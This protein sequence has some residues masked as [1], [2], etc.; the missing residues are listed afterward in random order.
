MPNAVEARLLKQDLPARD[1]KRVQDAVNTYYNLHVKFNKDKLSQE[2]KWRLF[3]RILKNALDRNLA[4]HWH[5]A[6]GNGVGY[7]CKV[8]QGAMGIWKFPDGCVVVIWK[9]PGL[10]P[11][12]ESVKEEG[13]K[14]EKAVRAKPAKLLFGDAKAEVEAVCQE[15]SSVDTK[16]AQ[17]LAAAI[18]KRLTKDFGPIWH[19]LAG[20][21]FVVEMGQDCRNEFGIQVGDTRIVGFQHEQLNGGLFP[22]LDLQKLLSAVPY[23]LMLLLC[24]GYMALSS[25]CK[26][27]PESETLRVLNQQI[28]GG[29]WEPMLR[30]VGVV[31]IVSA[32]CSRTLPRV[33]NG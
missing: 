16:D 13:A 17:V 15:M 21:S 19:V 5:V 22:S 27:I 31:V 11:E 1:R 25:L 14:S 7:A 10:E 12:A 2:E 24:F 6:V 26:D 4:A 9:S 32:F 30:N 8:R 18:R 29:S 20:P 28:C 33:F 23:L 3:A